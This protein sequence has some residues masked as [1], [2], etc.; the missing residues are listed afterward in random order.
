MPRLQIR[1]AQLAQFNYILVVGEKEQV[2]RTVNVR[3]RDNNVHGE[4][5]LASV[6]DVMSRERDERSLVGLFGAADGAASGAA[7]DAPAA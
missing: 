4:H 1:E 7:T 2:A 3:T 6:I 5:A